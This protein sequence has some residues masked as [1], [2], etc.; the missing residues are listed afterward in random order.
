MKYKSLIAA[1]IAAASMPAAHAQKGDG[2]IQ[3]EEVIVTARKRAESVQDVP[4]AI[5]PFQTEQLEQRDIQTMEDLATNTIGMS[6][7]GGIS[8]G[9]QATV[10]IRGL[11]TNFIQDRFQN[12]GIYLDGLYLQRQSMMNIGMVGL[13]RVEVVKG[14]QNAIYGRNAFAGAVN[15]VTQRPGEEFEA[16]L[17]TTQGNHERED[18]RAM[19]S[20]PLVEGKLFGRL[21]GGIS[22][23][24]GANENPHPFA[25]ADVPGFTNEGN[26]GGWDD[27]TISA[28]MIW[29]PTD[30]V[31][32]SVGYY[33][34]DLKRE[35]QGSY[36]INGLQEV[37]RFATSEFDDM[38]GNT[39]TLPSV[40]LPL[41][42][43]GNT[44]WFG[45]VPYL[46]APGNYISP[47]GDAIEDPSIP[48]AVDPRGYGSIAETELWNL[49]LSWDISEDW[50]LRYQFGDIQHDSRTSGPAAR[51]PLQG[52]TYQ[53]IAVNIQSSDFS[54][55]PNSTMETQSHELRLDWNGGDRL[56]LSGG[57]YFSETEDESHDLT[58]FAPVCSDR[59]L[60]GNGTNEDE[61]ANCNLEIVAGMPG[62]L[63]DAVFSGVLDFF[64]TF[65]N[66]SKSNNSQFD[67]EVRAI[68]AELSYDITDT[69]V[70]RLEG[71]YTEEE[72]KINRLTD[73]FGLAPGEVGCGTGLITGEV[74]FE[75]NIEV[76]QDED[77][78]DYFT[79]RVSIDWSWGDQNMV[80]A[81]AAKGVKSG[82][83]NNSLSPED[84]RFEPEENWTYEIGSKNVFFDN[85]LTLNLAA[86]YIDWKDLQGSVSPSVQ[87][88]NSNVVTVNIGDA[89]N[90]GFELETTYRFS[91]AWSIDAGYT[92]INPEY[93]DGA[94]YDAAARYYYWQCPKDVIEPG[95][96]CGETN[97]GGN[98]LARTSKE[99]AIVALNYARDWFD[100]WMFAGRL[101][102]SYRS[103]QYQTPIN[104][105]YIGSRTLFN[106]SLNI[107]SPA[108][109]WD[110]TLWG[111]NLTDEKYVSGSFTTALFNKFL[112]A[113][114]Q[115]RTYGLTLKYNF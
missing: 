89:T 90:Y 65:W 102:A 24:D 44:M 111:K 59:D 35:F 76:P 86:F 32:L 105:G 67:D 64:N 6:Y 78:F 72:R 39:K 12:V 10:T 33:D 17:M 9:V 53:D 74:C 1:A 100:G 91:D 95:E 81:Y 52:S 98:Q 38:N 75:S 106:G 41:P 101:D 92:W 84:L 82:G 16:Y 62:P 80:Y 36:F 58:V 2:A 112:V 114:G 26:L 104:T 77:V 115:R 73:N 51:D 88:Q 83:F 93:E 103:K 109:N 23:F 13:A 15:Y 49:K 113:Q 94:T 19:V 46:P 28:S 108:Q 34:T 30:T 5:T 60:N 71:R 87:S 48:G 45:E 11:A 22:E 54:S 27:Q 97:M 55:R 70:L 7:N 25:D 21:S 3:L 66:G 43:T 37:A 79:P 68:F 61:I 4:L 8:S 57:I 56:F 99:Q 69:V 40:G 18:Y 96:R 20:G 31:E 85:K 63:D 110:I 42:V 29:T 47:F 14:P 50:S 107:S